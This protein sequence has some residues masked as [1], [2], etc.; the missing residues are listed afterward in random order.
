MRVL[1]F[2]RLQSVS[3]GYLNG[4]TMHEFSVGRWPNYLCVTL[5]KW[6]YWFFPRRHFA[7][8]QLEWPRIVR[9]WLETEDD[10]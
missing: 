8:G 2:K 3:I 10:E 6:R 4:A 7:T 9:V 1:P 5:L